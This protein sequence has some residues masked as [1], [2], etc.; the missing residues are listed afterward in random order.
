MDVIKKHRFVL[1]QGENLKRPSEITEEEEYNKMFDELLNEMKKDWNHYGGLCRKCF[2]R[3]TE[4]VEE[5]TQDESEE[6]MDSDY[7]DD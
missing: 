5:P 2:E 3:N 6:E 7:T 1:C 4:F